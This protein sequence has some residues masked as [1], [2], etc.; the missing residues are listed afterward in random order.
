MSDMTL[1]VA[2]LAFSPDL[3]HVA[4]IQKK[5]PDWQA[6]KLNGIGGH[7][8][9]G[10]TPLA[11]M[12]REFEEE[13]GVREE[14]WREFGELRSDSQNWCVYWFW[15]VMDL[16]QLRSITDEP[17]KIGPVFGLCLG[18]LPTIPNL[19]YLVLMALNDVLGLDSCSR[20]TIREDS[21]RSKSPEKE[22]A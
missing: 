2:G 1:Y 4:L 15:S 16:S 11:A 7:I 20:L 5:R 3:Q 13:T 21:Y 19:R 14:N 17:I 22:G 8:E 12:I 10:E 9:P 6:G 18:H